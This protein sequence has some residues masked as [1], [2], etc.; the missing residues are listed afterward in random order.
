ML[1]GVG[2][3]GQFGRRSD[4]SPWESAATYFAAAA[5]SAF[6]FSSCAFDTSGFGVASPSSFPR[7]QLTPPSSDCM[8]LGLVQT[9]SRWPRLMC[10]TRPSPYCLTQAIGTWYGCLSLV[11][12]MFRLI[13]TWTF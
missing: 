3:F 4:H 11:L 7:I 2:E 12:A 13:R 6:D 8:Y 5:A 1:P 9:S 10:S